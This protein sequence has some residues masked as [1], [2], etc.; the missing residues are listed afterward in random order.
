MLLLF[1]AFLV[2]EHP[3]EILEIWWLHK[4]DGSELIYS[5]STPFSEMKRVRPALTSFAVQIVK[6][7]V[8]REA[9]AAFERFRSDVQDIL[10]EERLACGLV[11]EFPVA[12]GHRLK[13]F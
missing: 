2:A 7:K 6:E 8:V 1:T 9:K 12:L 3:S 5:T 13:N 4:D 10:W 11:R